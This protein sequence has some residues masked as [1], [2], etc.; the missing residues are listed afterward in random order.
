[1]EK[2]TANVEYFRSHL[3]ELLSQPL[4]HG[5]FVVVHD[6][7]VKGTFDTFGGA[8]GFA[9]ERFPAD[10]FIVQQVLDDDESISFL[11]AAL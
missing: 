2:K 5:K 10:E 11:R 6:Q 3:K 4:L 1:M 9:V 7:Q 8:L